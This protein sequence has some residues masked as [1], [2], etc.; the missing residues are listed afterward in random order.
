MGYTVVRGGTRAMLAAE[1]MLD[2]VRLGAFRAAPEAAP[3]VAQQLEMILSAQRHAVDRVMCEAGFY[4]PRLAALAIMQ[5]EGDVIHASFV[6]R[7]LRVSL[8]RR[9]T[10]GQRPIGWFKRPRAEPPA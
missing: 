4:A 10:A 7:A 6:L 3:E 1:E 9:G 2:A 5:A 8:P